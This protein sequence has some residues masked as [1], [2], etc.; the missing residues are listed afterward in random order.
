[1]PSQY[2]LIMIYNQEA[3]INVTSQAHGGNALF[4]G[5]YW[6]S[7]IT[8]SMLT[9]NCNNGATGSPYYVWTVHFPAPNNNETPCCPWVASLP[10]RAIRAF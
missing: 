10:V 9:Q 7:T 1:M 8:S 3:A 6:P 4:A 5:G 2:E